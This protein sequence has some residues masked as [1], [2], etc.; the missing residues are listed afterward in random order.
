MNNAKTT[1]MSEKDVVDSGFYPDFSRFRYSHGDCLVDMCDYNDSLILDNDGNEIGFAHRAIK[2][3]CHVAPEWKEDVLNGR[4]SAT[5]LKLLV[6]PKFLDANPDAGWNEMFD[7]EQ[8]IFVRSVFGD[9]L[10]KL[11]AMQRKR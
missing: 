7:W 1:Y 9:N 8:A 4:I 11:V 5:S 10:A 3:N 6:H 2:V